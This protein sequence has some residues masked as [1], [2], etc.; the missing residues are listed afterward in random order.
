MIDGNTLQRVQME[1]FDLDDEL[2]FERFVKGN[3]H[4][5]K[6][7]GTELT[8]SYDPMKRTGVCIS[9]LGASRAIAIGA[10][11]LALTAIDA[12]K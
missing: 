11:T 10:Y 3:A 12:C 5:L 6:V 7:Y 4:P 1:V 9:R 8:V 2:E